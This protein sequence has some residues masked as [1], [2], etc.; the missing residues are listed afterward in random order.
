MKSVSHTPPPRRRAFWIGFIASLAV[1]CMAGMVF[2]ACHGQF[3]DFAQHALRRAGGRAP[4][5]RIDAE[6]V[7]ARLRRAAGP[8][9][10]FPLPLPHLLVCK[11]YKELDLFSGE[12]FIKRYKVSLAN[13]ADGT[14]YIAAHALPRGKEPVFIGL[15]TRLTTGT[16]ASASPSIG[17]LGMGGEAGAPG[18][19]VSGPSNSRSVIGMPEG[20]AAE[21][22]VA[23]PAGAPVVIEQ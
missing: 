1:C 22:L 11:E 8:D 12:R 20:D 14:F 7:K 18:P 19:T 17:I 21:I 4:A 13:P 10:A 16:A 9:L 2:L 23:T 15:D 3:G 6:A 5:S